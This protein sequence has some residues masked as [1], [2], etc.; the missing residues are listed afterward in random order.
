[1]ARIDRAE[2]FIAWV[3]TFG[4]VVVGWVF[5]RA[6]TLAGALQILRGM[7]GNNGCALPSGWFG[8]VDLGQVPGAQ[9][10]NGQ[11]AWIWCGGLAAIAL[12]LP[13][14][15]EIMRNHLTGITRPSEPPQGLA[16]SVITFSSTPVWAA[17]TAALITAGLISLPQPTSFLYF[18]F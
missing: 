16:A 6:H 13:N 17:L 11:L 9:I 3:L 15:Q 18:N 1:M 10:A 12:L 2:N 8:C 14:T 7:S 5:F 4:A